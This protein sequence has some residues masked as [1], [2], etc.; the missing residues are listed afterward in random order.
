MAIVLGV[1]IIVFAGF[2][3]RSEEPG[4]VTKSDGTA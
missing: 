2:R 4:T 1:A 3:H